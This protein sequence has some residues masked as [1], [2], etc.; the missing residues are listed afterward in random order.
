[1]IYRTIGP[2]LATRPLTDIERARNL[3][4][5]ARAADGL[6]MHEVSELLSSWAHPS[7]M[8]H[9]REALFARLYDPCPS[10]GPVLGKPVRPCRSLPYLPGRRSAA[11]VL[12]AALTY[13]EK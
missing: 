2:V 8:T 6:A 13:G 5:L 7:L 9:R 10:P 3:E 1:M 12:L 11:R 4:W